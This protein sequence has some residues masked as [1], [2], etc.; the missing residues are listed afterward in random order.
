MEIQIGRVVDISQQIDLANNTLRTPVTVEIEASR[1]VILPFNAK[2][3]LTS[4]V[5]MN[6][7]L[8]QLIRKGLRAKLATVSL[9]TGYQYVQLSIVP[10]APPMK[11]TANARRHQHHSRHRRRKHSRH[12]GGRDRSCWP[13]SMSWSAM[14]IRWSAI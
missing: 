11:L 1:M 6:A 13:M 9:L 2:Q 14:P 10:D 4:Q 5:A 8:D 3:K 12:D 7:A